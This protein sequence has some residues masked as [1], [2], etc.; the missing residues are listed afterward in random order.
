MNEKTRRA[1]ER[2]EDRFLALKAIAGMRIAEDTNRAE[3]LALC[4]AIAR[5]EVEKCG[6]E[7]STIGKEP[8]SLLGG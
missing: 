6:V 3:T 4:M 2:S 8:R 7:C 5:I 1:L